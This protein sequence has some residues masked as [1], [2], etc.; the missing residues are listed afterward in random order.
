MDRFY[1]EF[2]TYG[3]FGRASDIGHFWPLLRPVIGDAVRRRGICRVLEFGAGRSGFGEELLRTKLR[4]VVLLTLH[5]VTASNRSWLDREG[6]QVII[7]RVEEITGEYDLIFS[8]FVLEHM[9]D[10]EAALRHLWSLLA[11]RGGLF[12]TSPRYDMPFYLPPSCDHL[13]WPAR[14]VTGLAVAYWRIRTAVFGRPAFLLL[15]DLSMFHLP[16]RRDR[17]AVHLV[18]LYDLRA[19]FGRL[20]G[21]ITRLRNLWTGNLGLLLTWGGLKDYIVKRH[22]LICL[23]VERE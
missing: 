21:R 12:L 17:D 5:D 20:G 13:P 11:P 7:G 22:L 19:L 2:P 23:Q 15:D 1:Q 6:D 3:A 10:P 8:T 18:S 16:W 4:S 14:V 9:T